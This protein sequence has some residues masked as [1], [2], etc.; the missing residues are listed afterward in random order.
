MLG[1]EVSA[2]RISMLG[3]RHNPL[4]WCVGSTGGMLLALSK[5]MLIMLTPFYSDV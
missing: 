1:V 2:P 5:T 3:I 4:V